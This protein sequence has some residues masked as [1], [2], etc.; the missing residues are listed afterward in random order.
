MTILLSITTGFILCHV[1]VVR[2]L[3]QHCTWLNSRLDDTHTAYQR[4]LE[5]LWIR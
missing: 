4:L 1:T 5:N 3:K 2:G